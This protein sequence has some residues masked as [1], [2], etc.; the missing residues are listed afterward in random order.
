MQKWVWAIED[1]SMDQSGKRIVT[2]QTKL[3]SYFVTDN[4]PTQTNTPEMDKIRLSEANHSPWIVFH[5]T[6][7]W[8]QPNLDELYE[9]E[10]THRREIEGRYLNAPQVLPARLFDVDISSI[11]SPW[12]VFDMSSPVHF[13]GIRH[14][15]VD[16]NG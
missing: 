2:T 4:E 9:M 6:P 12:T 11:S 13:P 10:T 7:P 15:D 3:R 1:D 5:V 16:Q 14:S 8:N